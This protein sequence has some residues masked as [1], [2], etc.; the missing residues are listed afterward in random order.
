[1]QLDYSTFLIFIFFSL[2]S[3]TLVFNGIGQ[4]VIF[5]LKVESIYLFICLYISIMLLL[6]TLLGNKAPCGTHKGSPA[7]PA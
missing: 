5:T 6:F 4:V 3:V 2:Y 7:C 1:M